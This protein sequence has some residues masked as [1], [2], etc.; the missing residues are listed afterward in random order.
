MTSKYSIYEQFKQQEQ[1]LQSD[2]EKAK[3]IQ[4]GNQVFKTPNNTTARQENYTSIKLFSNQ[5]NSQV[6]SSLISFLS[7][8]TDFPNNHKE[9]ILNV[10]K[11]KRKL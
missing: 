1:D 7:Q 6:S 10:K 3:I 8:G 9:Q 5:K 11:R 2:E 4:D